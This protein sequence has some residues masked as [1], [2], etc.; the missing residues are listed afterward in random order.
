MNTLF[1]YGFIVLLFTSCSQENKETKAAP[2]PEQKSPLH[3]EHLS[4]LR[5]SDK[6][7]MRLDTLQKN[8][9]GTID[10]SVF[11]SK[12]LFDLKFKRIPVEIGGGLIDGDEQDATF[13]LVNE[14]FKADW[15]VIKRTSK[16][17]LIK[18]DG[19]LATLRYDLHLIDAINGYRG[20]PASN[21]NYQ[22][23]RSA[24][25]NPDNLTV[26]LTNEYNVKTENGKFEH[27]EM[28]QHFFIDSKGYFKERQAPKQ[29]ASD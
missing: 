26:V 13:S 24:T 18:V 8:I 6:V 12:K 27:E 11:K 5:D 15:Q 29:K 3:K 16:F 23:G 19:I 21:S 14:T 10:L 20:D 4:V 7:A 9:S 28:K 22:A 2:E 25:V 1:K 17:F